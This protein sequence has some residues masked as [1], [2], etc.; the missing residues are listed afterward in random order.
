METY[1]PL[2]GLFLSFD[3]VTGLT[4]GYAFATYEN[5]SVTDAAIQG[6]HGLQIGDRTLVVRR[7]DAALNQKQDQGSFDTIV[8]EPVNSFLKKFRLTIKMNFEK[9]AAATTTLCMLQMVTAEDLRD[10]EEVVDITTDIRT[11]CQ[12]FGNVTQIF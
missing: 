11:E 2:R 12:N 8:K 9:T 6:L 7:H 10:P 1:G 4:K 5:E 3:P